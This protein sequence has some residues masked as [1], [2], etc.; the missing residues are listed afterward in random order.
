ML[1][2]NNK[3]LE[4][5]RLSQ[6]HFSSLGQFDFDVFHRLDNALA[7]GDVVRFGVDGEALNH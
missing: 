3:L 1:L 7:R 5:Q 2:E 6:Q 4:E